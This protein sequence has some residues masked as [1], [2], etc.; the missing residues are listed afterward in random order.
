MSRRSTCRDTA[1][2]HA[3]KL[4]RRC[5]VELIDCSQQPPY[6][7]L[8]AL[9]KVHDI[10]HT[11]AG[12]L[13][14]PLLEGQVGG[15][16]DEGL[17]DINRRAGVLRYLISLPFFPRVRPVLIVLAFPGLTEELQLLEE[18]GPHCLRRESRA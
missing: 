12:I 3:T 4:R 8:H 9:L 17:P 11:A 1:Y 13:P 18:R 2:T 14:P 15:V 6:L 16:F 7:A 5:T 10:T